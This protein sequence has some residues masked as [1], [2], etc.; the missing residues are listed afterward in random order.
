MAQLEVHH[1]QLGVEV[2]DL[3]DGKLRIGRKSDNDVII[4]SDE[5]VS[6][7]H[8]EVEKT[9]QGFA[10]QDL[11]SSNGTMMEGMK[12]VRV[13]LRPDTEFFVGA[14]RCKFLADAAEAPS[15]PPAE[16]APDPLQNAFADDDDVLTLTPEDEA[17]GAL[18]PTPELAPAMSGD[19]GIQLT[20]V[21][22]YTAETEEDERQAFNTSQYRIGSIDALATAGRDIPFDASAIAMINARGQTVHAAEHDEGATALTLRILRMMLLGCIRCGASDIHLE[23]RR[24]GCLARLRIDGAMVEIAELDADAARRLYSLIKVLCDIDITKKAIVQ[25][26]HFSVNAPGRRIDYRISFTPAMFGQKLVIRVLDP[27]NAPQKLRDLELPGWMY[28]KIRDT[29]KQDTGMLLVCG[30][31]GSGKTTTLYAV[32]RQI[33]ASLRNVLTIEDPVEYEVAGVTQIPVDED[34][35]ATFHSL[36]RSCLRQDPDVIVLGEIRDKDTATTAMQAATTGHLVLSTIHAKDTIGT[37]FRL[38]DL[39]C[40]PY[41]VAST[42][43]LVLAQRLARRLCPHCKEPRKATPEQIRKL[44]KSVEGV[45]QLYVPVGC[46]ECF[47]TGYNG[48]RGVYELLAATDEL[49]D[50]ILNNPGIGEIKKTIEMSMF[51]SLRDTGYQLAMAGETSLEE[52]ARVIGVD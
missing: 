36:L 44:G 23:P 38:L 11:N 26:G 24:S 50:I 31:T 17:E 35:G 32:L 46:P 16:P 25:E 52:V 13:V 1:K 49:R 21:D 30:P 14:T 3:P 37:V 22:P 20:T 48:R 5:L 29:A 34:S 27:E 19:D 45:K 4:T 43:N 6:R 41:L 42:L 9:P 47:G 7:Y 12:I 18:I 40:E 28:N 2:I 51:T 15:S 33:D 8:C 39:G 10:L